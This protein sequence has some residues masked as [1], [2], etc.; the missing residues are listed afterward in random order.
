MMP[1]LEDAATEAT[2]WRI[3][4]R[5]AVYEFVY[6]AAVSLPLTIEGRIAV[7]ESVIGAGVSEGVSAALVTVTIRVVLVVDRIVIVVVG[8][9]E[10]EVE[11]CLHGQHEARFKFV[12]C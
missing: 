6:G 2:G 3:L 1:P 7:K 5:G 10:V 4:G 12:I 9:S 8:S 11:T